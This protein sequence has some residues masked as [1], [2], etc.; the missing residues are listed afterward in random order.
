MTAPFVTVGTTAGP[1]NARTDPETGL[2]FYAWQGRELPSATTVRNIAGI[3]YR[4]HTWTISQVVARAVEGHD[5]LGA[6][7]ARERRPRERVLEKNRI[8]EASA[9]LRSAATEE[10]DASSKLGTLVHDA[11]AMD[12]ALDDLEPAVRPRVSQFRQWLLRS[13]AERLASEFQVFNLAEGYAG[14]ADL[15]V[16]F[17]NGQVWLVDLKTGKSTYAEHALQ[18]TFY[19]MA[20]FSGRDD[21]VDPHVTG[22][23][24]GAS[25][26][27]VLHLSDDDWEFRSIRLDQET[28]DAARGLLRFATWTHVHRE[29]GD[30]TLAS[31]RSA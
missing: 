19:R 24:R 20:E 18:L 8:A 5:E 27:A 1:P 3:P 15:L 31:R 25:G 17:P 16:R 11:C 9:W 22:L 26:M 12:V 23:L 13:G 4:L 14:T 10:R 28:W 30:V 21:V 29:I 2:R 7:L 6:M